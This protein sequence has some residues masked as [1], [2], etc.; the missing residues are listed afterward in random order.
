MLFAVVLW[1]NQMYVCRTDGEVYDRTTDISG[2]GYEVFLCKL[3]VRDAW[4]ESYDHRSCDSG[5]APQQRDH[6]SGGIAIPQEEGREN[7]SFIDLTGYLS[8]YQKT[9]CQMGECLRREIKEQLGLLATYGIGT[10]MYLAKVALD[11]I[12]RRFCPCLA[13]DICQKLLTCFAA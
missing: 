3:R 9:P 11:V 5:S 8:A 1:F 13:P 10:N 6:L 7:E 2:G 4:P 12:A